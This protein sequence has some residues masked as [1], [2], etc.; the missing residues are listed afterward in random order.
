MFF[1]RA[2][3]PLSMYL[4]LKDV[5]IVPAWTAI[6]IASGGNRKH[7]GKKWWHL[8]EGP[9]NAGGNIA[10]RAGSFDGGSKTARKLY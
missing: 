5:K 2:F 6:A 3:S 10:S 4:E 7:P 1:K 8:C 9:P